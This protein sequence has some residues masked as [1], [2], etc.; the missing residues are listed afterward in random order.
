MGNISSDGSFDFGLHVFTDKFIYIDVAP[1][2]SN[3]HLI[4]LINFQKHTL[5]TEPID[6]FW[7]SDEHDLELCSVG[8]LVDELA[9]RFVDQ[10]MSF[11]NVNVFFLSTFIKLKFEI[12]DSLLNHPN[13]IIVLYLYIDYLLFLL[14][15]QS[16]HSVF[17][18]FYFNFTGFYFDEF[19]LQLCNL[20]NQLLVIFLDQFFC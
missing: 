6:A 19:L 14:F 7:L 3:L 15:D 18:F 10:V 9:Q 12:N 16:L 13:C 5:R 17:F 11:R 1:T 2:H 4:F 20:L 8:D